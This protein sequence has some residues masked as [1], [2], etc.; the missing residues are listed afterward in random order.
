MLHVRTAQTTLENILRDAITQAF[1]RR[2]PPVASIAALRLVGTQGASGDST[3]THEDLI[4]VVAGGS[5]PN[6]AYRWLESSTDADDGAETIQPA[7]RAPGLPGRW[8]LWS[9]PLRYSPDVSSPGDLDSYTLDALP[10]FDEQHMPLQRVI[11][12]DKRLEVDEMLEL[13]LAQMPCVFITADGDD[14]SDLTLQ[15]GY[16]WKN[17]YRFTITVVASNLRDGNEATQ[18]SSVAADPFPGAN[19]IDGMIWELIGGTTLFDVEE[20]ILNVWPTRGDNYDTA[21]NGQRAV[22]RER[23]WSV[24]A[25]VEKPQAPNEAGPIQEITGQAHLADLGEQEEFDPANVVTLGLRVPLGT[26]L[27]KQVAAG[28]CEIDGQLV[29]FAGELRTFGASVDTYRDLNGNGTMTYTAVPYDEIPPAPA[30]GA[31]RIAVT[32]TD[33]A[34]VVSDTMLSSSFVP[35]GPQFD[36]TDLDT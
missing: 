13:A 28:T 24:L 5:T 17:T 16:R 21:L 3:R 35:Y 4:S 20:S 32:R 12:L 8:R 11:V 18:G 29:S 14:D 30:T 26:G 25:V 9:T 6:V 15:S 23:M 19:T 31:L 22:L 33:G 34:G 27:T 10:Y 1:R 36:D 7:D 2:L